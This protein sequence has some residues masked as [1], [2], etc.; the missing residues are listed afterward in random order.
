MYNHKILVTTAEE[1]IPRQVL[2]NDLGKKELIE[3]FLILCQMHAVSRSLS[4]QI[5]GIQHYLNSPYTRDLKFFPAPSLRQRATTIH[6]F[7][8][9]IQISLATDIDFKPLATVALEAQNNDLYQRLLFNRVDPG[10]SQDEINEFELIIW[11]AINSDNGRV[12]KATSHRKRRDAPL[13]VCAIYFMGAKSEMGIYGEECY[14]YK[15]KSMN[16][17]LLKFRHKELERLR[18]KHLKGE[19]NVIWH[20]YSVHPSY[21]STE[22]CSSMIRWGFEHYGLAHE[23]IWLETTEPELFLAYGWEQVDVLDM[24]LRKWGGEYKGYGTHRT[25]ILVRKPGALTRKEEN[26]SIDEKNGMV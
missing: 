10:S 17:E 5:R 15:G 3:L 16:V 13:G 1:T 22:L 2:A 14:R 8:K 6:V 9:S 21:N 20:Q 23:T 11:S 4:H 24:D 12:W 7:D 18:W 26:G 25:Y 19:K